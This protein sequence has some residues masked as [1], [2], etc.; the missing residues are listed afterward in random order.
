MSAVPTAEN[1]RVKSL[2]GSVA[3]SGHGIA[4]GSVSRSLLALHGRKGTTAKVFVHQVAATC[5]KSQDGILFMLFGRPASDGW[6]CR[7][8]D[9]GGGGGGSFHFVHC[10]SFAIKS[11]Q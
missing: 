9:G 1:S 3:T 8:N 5:K 2:S 6:P 10:S 11:Y 7:Y 4:G